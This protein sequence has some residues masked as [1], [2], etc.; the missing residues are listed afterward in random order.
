[1]MS[2]D[3]ISAIPS[4]IGGGF[5][6]GAFLGYFIR[7][8]IKIILFALGGI[9][10]LLMYLQYQELITVNTAKFESYTDGIVSTISNANSTIE[11]WNHIIP[12]GAANFGIPLTSS[13]AVGFTIGFLRA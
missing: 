4:L 6:I 8:V 7:K 5:L 9:L 12:L 13:M 2:F 10:A 11:P 1:M 3:N